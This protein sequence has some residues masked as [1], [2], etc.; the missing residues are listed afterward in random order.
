MSKALLKPEGPAEG[1]ESKSD[2]DGKLAHKGA[3]KRPS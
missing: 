3:D 2:A 1:G